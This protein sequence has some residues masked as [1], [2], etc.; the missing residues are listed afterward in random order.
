MP[1]GAVDRPL[2]W[3]G[4]PPNLKMLSP[5]TLDIEFLIE[6]AH[7]AGAEIMEVYAGHVEVERKDDASPVTAADLRSHEVIVERLRQANPQIPILSEENAE[8]ASY[9]V[10]KHWRECWLVDPLDGTKEFLKRNGQFTINIGLVQDSRPAWGL[11]YA[12]ALDRLY[13]G[14][15]KL[16]AF[17]VECGGMPCRLPEPGAADRTWR[18]VVASLSHPSPAMDAYVAEQRRQHD[19]V[20]FLAVGSALKLCLVAEGRADVYPRFGPTME[21]DTAAAH[22]I[23]NAAGKKVLRHGSDEELTYNKKDLRNSWFVVE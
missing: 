14:G 10:R 3:R 19:D 11:V 16:G 12:P 2:F 21:W 9:E 13:F 5:T 4:N 17:K 20:R 18:V 7:V 8:Q 1:V 15:G 22:A 6:T 23:V